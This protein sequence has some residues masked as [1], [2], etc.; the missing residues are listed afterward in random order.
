V[1][2]EWDGFTLDLYYKE[3]HRTSCDR[4]DLIELF[5]DLDYTT[6]NILIVNMKILNIH[7]GIN[8]FHK[9]VW[10]KVVKNSTYGTG[11][12]KL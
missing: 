8:N 5:P 2:I 6:L 10:L 7:N 11:K 9:D 3:G 1:H 12:Y 4:N